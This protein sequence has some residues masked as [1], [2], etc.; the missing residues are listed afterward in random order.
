[1]VRLTTFRPVVLLGVCVLLGGCGGHGKEDSLPPRPASSASPPASL[2]GG[3]AES[4][5]SM[6]LSAR[7]LH[8]RGATYRREHA[9]PRNPSG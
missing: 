2:P 4:N 7:A 6:P 8:R 1:M 9:M 5:V 3:Q